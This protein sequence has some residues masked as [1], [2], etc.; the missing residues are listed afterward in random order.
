MSG[1]PTFRACL[2]GSIK[3]RGTA[4]NPVGRFEGHRRALTDDG[5]HTLNL[6]AEEEVE[7]GWPTE[8]RFETS[9]SAI[10]RNSSPDVPFDR[11][12]NPYRGCEHGCIYCFARPTHAYYGL[13]PGLDFET[14]LTARNNLPELLERELSAVNYKPAPLALGANT[15]PYQPIERQLELTRGVVVVLTRTRHPFGIVTKSALVTRDIDLL[16]PAAADGAAHV[17]I[18]LTTLDRDLARKLEPRAASPHRR[19]QAIEALAKAGI[20]VAVLA[21]PMIPGLNDHELEAILTAGRDAGATDANTILV[22][23]PLEISDLFQDW[24][25]AHHPLKADRVMN[26]IRGCRDGKDYRSNFGT[27]M[28]GTGGYADL[29]MTRFKKAR[30]RLGLNQDRWEV[31]GDHFQSP[32]SLREPKLL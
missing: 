21:S 10:T 12:I 25:R 18:S 1:A 26:L 28:R 27:R 32:A 17:S 5:W 6:L 2:A 11:S 22:R 14:K 15:D 3:G 23:L 29:L 9:K 4:R 16:T 19:L 7:N 13:S 20:P 31:V 24:L 30:K 8:V